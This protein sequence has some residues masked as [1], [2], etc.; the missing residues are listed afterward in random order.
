MNDKT[1]QNTTPQSAK[2]VL[3]T[4]VATKH[5]PRSNIKQTRHRIVCFVF[6]WIPVPPYHAFN[7]IIKNCKSVICISYYFE[8]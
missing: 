5:T 3:L 8:D 6:S 2:V 4:Q 1:E 7:I